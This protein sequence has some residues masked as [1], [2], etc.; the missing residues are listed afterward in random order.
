V[1]GSSSVKIFSFVEYDKLHRCSDI[2]HVGTN[3]T[4]NLGKDLPSFRE[5]SYNNKQ[6]G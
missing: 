5:H 1:G 2:S 3:S 6:E 4:K